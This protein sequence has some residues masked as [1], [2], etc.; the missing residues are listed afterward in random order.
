MIG[1]GT[2]GMARIHAP[3]SSNTLFF[4]E[5]LLEITEWIPT[6]QLLQRHHVGSHVV[7]PASILPAHELFFHTTGTCRN[8][9]ALGVKLSTPRLMS[10]VL[11]LQ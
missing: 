7:T 8:T 10:R 2:V 5:R 9:P 4:P 6:A 1:K 11:A 3:K